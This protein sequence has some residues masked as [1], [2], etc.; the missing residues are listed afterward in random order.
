MIGPPLSPEQE[1]FPPAA[2]PAQNMLVVTAD[3]PYSDWQEVREMT[4]TETFLKADGKVD[5]DSLVRP[6]FYILA[7]SSEWVL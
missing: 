3:V 7:L 6:L 4:G 2:N 1:S 5:P